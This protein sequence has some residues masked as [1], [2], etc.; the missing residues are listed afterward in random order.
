MTVDKR[1][2]LSVP[3]EEFAVW[4][5]AEE[6][7]A[8][9]ANADLLDWWPGFKLRLTREAARLSTMR[10]APAAAAAVAQRAAAA[11]LRDAMDVAAR[12]R[13]VGHTGGVP[14]GF[15]AGDVAPIFK[16]GDPAEPTNYRPITL[17][18]TGYRV[19]TKTL[20]ARLA[21]VLATV[22]GPHQT[23]FLPGRLITDNVLFMHL[24]PHLL[25]SNRAAGD[26]DTAVVAAFLDFSKAYDT[27]SRP[28]LYAVM[29]AMGAGDGLLHWTRAILTGTTASATVNGFTFAAQP[30]H[31][32]VRQGCPVAPALFLFAA[33]ALVR[34]LHGCPSVG[35]DIARGVR[36]FCVQYADDTLPLLRQLTPACVQAFLA[37]MHVF[38]MASRLAL[39]PPKSQLLAL[40]DAVP[41]DGVLP[42][43]V[44]GLAVVTE[45]AS[46][47]AVVEAGGEPQPDWEELLDQV[48][49]K[50]DKLA[51]LP[52]FAFGR[53]SAAAAYGVG[54]LLHR[55]TM[56]AVPQ[57]VFDRL[58]RISKR[59]VDAGHMLESWSHRDHDVDDCLTPEVAAVYAVLPAEW[60]AD[61]ARRLPPV[62]TPQ[63]TLPVA[64][65]AAEE[66][67][68]ARAVAA[69][70]GWRS[71]PKTGQEP[72]WVIP[73][74]DP[75]G[76]SVRDAT[77]LQLQGFEG[78]RRACHTDYFTAALLLSGTPA[79]AASPA[80]VEAGRA[81]VAIALRRVWM[82]GCKNTLKETLW[83]V[84]LNGVPGAGGG[85]IIFTAPCPCGWHPTYGPRPDLMWRSH[86]FWE[87]RVATAVVGAVRAGLEAKGVLAG[88]LACRHVWLLQPPDAAVYADVWRVVCVA[89]LDAMAYGRRL[90]WA[91]HLDTGAA[92]P[93]DQSLIT[94]FFPVLTAGPAQPD[95]ADRAGRA[96]VAR[97]W[98]GLQE[99]ASLDRVPPA[100][101]A[102]DG[103]PP[104]HPFIGV[105]R[106]GDRPRLCLHAP[107]DPP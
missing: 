23:A 28:F 32:G 72:G 46:L 39:N 93:D 94:D 7:V 49:L 18:S 69:C 4:L 30:Y 27:V 43:S 76:L 54:R 16:K 41:P 10:A 74:V 47:G 107:V 44:C 22:V 21:P 80:V 51:R 82:L 88:A 63:P 62:L 68:A 97:F 9:A 67:A 59:L 15:L 11:E 5:E 50:Y 73:L 71:G 81:S 65:P 66:A 1:M 91:L 98:T 26:G 90:L 53:A 25:A 17:L 70:V 89:A 92:P 103:P 83:R 78:T 102:A 38:Q 61:A 101:A 29:E 45:A 86:Y 36:V 57:W 104:D 13:A 58:H 95:K 105:V 106:A 6:D 8:P 48:A 34:H 42:E 12:A 85:G 2:P 20:A 96:A 14:R 77:G 40:G 35:I 3:P 79:L 64:L 99:I 24:L 33:E 100:W 55:A 37:F 31:A 84:T 56:H 87:C 19:M 60:R 75:G 52:L